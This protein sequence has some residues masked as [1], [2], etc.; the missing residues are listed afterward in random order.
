MICAGYAA[1]ARHYLLWACRQPRAG[2]AERGRAVAIALKA[3]PPSIPPGLYAR[4]IHLRGPAIV[5]LYCLLGRGDWEAGHDSAN[6][7][8]YDLLSAN[9]PYKSTG[10]VRPYLQASA[11]LRRDASVS[12]ENLVGVSER[13]SI[14]APAGP[15]I[16]AQ[17]PDSARF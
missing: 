16:T 1:G 12:D 13:L 14:F 2:V 10:P 11:T 8:F 15:H 4:P 9:L 7:I 6:S 3:H 17:S 5:G